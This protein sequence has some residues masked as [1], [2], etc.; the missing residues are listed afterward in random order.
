NSALIAWVRT[1]AAQARFVMSLC[2][3][4]FVLAKA[5]VLDG[6]AM[7]TFPGDQDAFAQRFPK[8]DLRRGVSFVHD[9]KALTSQGGAR[10]YDPALYL[11]AHLYGEQAAQGV[12]RGLVLP[13]PPAPGTLPAVVIARNR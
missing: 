3:G 2:D 12:A 1:T 6:R 10:S 5:G 4:A 9:G 13:W 7:T 11:V 8:L